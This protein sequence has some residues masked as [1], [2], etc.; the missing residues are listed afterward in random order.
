[1]GLDLHNHQRKWQDAAQIIGRESFGRDA[2][3]WYAEFENITTTEA[4][5]ELPDAALKIGAPW[6]G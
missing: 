2:R 5:M 3:L 4:G 6:K 1:M